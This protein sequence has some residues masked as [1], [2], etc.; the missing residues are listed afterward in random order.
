MTR[1]LV[2]A[3]SSRSLGE[4]RRPWVRAVYTAYVRRY[5]SN[6]A[7]AL[8][9]L[10]PGSEVTLLAGRELVDREALPSHVTLRLYDE[11]S[12]KA[13]AEPLAALTARLVASWWPPRDAEPGLDIGGVWLPDL[14]P[15][16]KGIVLRLDVL[17]YLSAV[18]RV[19]DEVK[20]EHVI[21]ITGA[22]IPER[23]AE[24]FAADRGIPTTRA[25]RFP[26][27]LVVARVWQALHGRAERRRLRVLLTQPR[28]R[29]GAPA[30]GPRI[31]F[32]VCQARH[33]DMVA[34]LAESLRAAGVT[35]VVLA[36]TVEG[37]EME[38][39]LRGL[40]SRGVLWA[41][42]TDYLSSRAAR[43]LAR[44][45][46]PL[47]R[48]LLDRLDQD[49]TRRAQARHGTVDLAPT[50]APFGRQ[51]VRWSLLSARL[52]LEASLRALD[53][54]RPDAVIVV[55]DRRFPER[56]LA[57][58]ARARSIPT[59]LF[60]GGSLLGRDRINLFDIAD[61]IMV[62]GDHVRDG[63]VAQGIDAR[64]VAVVGDPRANGARL[65][66]LDRLRRDV[67]LDF[68]LAEN[69]PLVVV[70]S[71]YASVLFS[72]AEKAAFY[73]TVIDAVRH[74]DAVP[75]VVKA[76]PNENLELLRDQLLTWGWPDARL[77]QSYD[78]HRL[79]RAA[80]AAIM[81]TS[82]AGIE[83]MAMDCPVVA[84]QTRGK[85]FEGKYM[86]PYV[87]EGAAE[88]VAAGDPAA[89]AATL[90]RL[91]TDPVAR[92]ALIARGRR[93]A[94]RYV[95]PADGTLADRLLAC[96]AEVRAGSG[97]EPAR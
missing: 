89:L 90:R 62:M 22:S 36:S 3:E 79:F 33:L 38:T 43:R 1:T 31:A 85:D 96:L 2:V 21:S 57:L 27:S 58:A 44:E 7:T 80:D 45:S 30:G 20:P 55:S 95:R 26:A 66:P 72:A 81:V 39:R 70:V 50:I 63:L 61:R 53:A 18:E 65:V 32:A 42:F 40:T 5:R 29:V 60:W 25:L 16:A 69:A 41:Y 78:I 84:V 76:H 14:L 12:F 19:L 24:A 93:F 87:T 37:T 28:R 56:A 67:R 92:A 47:V 23:L 13:E 91:L 48:R 73:R 4:L 54:L 10:E 97:K 88:H 15:V 35:P 17:E 94:T 8:A 34:P 68:G 82:M 51:T 74:L 64:R 46:R 86:P 11:E 75:V 6:I 71:K 49:P 83:A 9:R 77:T 59:L 52:Y